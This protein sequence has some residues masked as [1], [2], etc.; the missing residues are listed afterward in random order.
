MSRISEA[1]KSIAERRA[2]LGVKQMSDIFD[3]IMSGS[4]ADEVL[5][6]FLTALKMKGETVD[7]IVGAAVSMRSKALF[8]NT[9]S[10]VPVDIVG[11]GGDGLNTL[12]I[13]TTSAFIIAGAGVCVAKHGNRAATSKSG[14]ADVLA[15]LGFNLDVSEAQVEYCLQENGIAFLFAQKMHPAMRYAAKVRRELG[16]RTVFNLLGPLANPAGSPYQVVGVSKPIHTELLANALK[17]LGAKRAMVVNSAE[18]MDEISPCALTRISELKNGSISTF[19]FNPYD[20]LGRA[21]NFDDLRGGD[22]Q[23]NAR[24]ALDILECRDDTAATDACLLNSAAGIL[25]SGA[26]CDFAEAF[27]MAKKSLNSGAAR[28]KLRVLVEDSKR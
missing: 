15:A 26:A 11:T 10:R 17:N 1:L 22:A 8:V 28:E 25:V 14:S 2:D 6:A 23:Y 13:S 12:N 16:F 18:G 24:R 20:Y 9:G 5:A 27:E 21:G 4:V 19:E 7:E 3:E